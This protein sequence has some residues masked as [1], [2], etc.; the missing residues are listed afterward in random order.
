MNAIEALAR[1]L[2]AAL[3]G[4]KIVLDRPD[5]PKG[6]W[7]LDARYGGNSVTLEWRPGKGGFG[8]SSSEIDGLE[9]SDERHPAPAALRRAQEILVS[10][11]KTRPPR[12]TSLPALRV[13]KAIR[14]ETVA[15]ALGVKQAQVSKLERQGNMRLDTL[16]KLVGA[17]GGQ[18]EIRARFE[19]DPG[20]VI[21]TGPWARTA[22]RRSQTKTRAVRRR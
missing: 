1:K 10:G 18:L 11:E 17:L 12:H 3:P 7:W 20:D 4:V 2:E 14:Q 16:R 22:R 5:D 21:I 15:R 8:L 19:G 13:E 6:T 9:G